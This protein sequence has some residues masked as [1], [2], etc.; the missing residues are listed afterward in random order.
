[1]GRAWAAAFAIAL[2]AGCARHGGSGRA[3]PGAGPLL[4]ADAA[5]VLGAVREPGAR[6]VLVNVWATWCQP[7]RE[8]F[9]ELMRVARENRPRGLRLLFVSDDFD[10]AHG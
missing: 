6:A 5:R 9:P 1:M 7:C 10:H 8:E 2:L 4:A 3:A